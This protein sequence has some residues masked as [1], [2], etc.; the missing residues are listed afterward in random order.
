MRAGVWIYA[1]SLDSQQWDIANMISMHKFMHTV[2]HKRP[3]R[4]QHDR[5]YFTV[6]K[7]GCCVAPVDMYT[8]IKGTASITLSHPVMISGAGNLQKGWG[9]QA[10]LHVRYFILLLESTSADWMS[11]TIKSWQRLNWEANRPQE[12][13]LPCRYQHLVYSHPIHEIS[14]IFTIHNTKVSGA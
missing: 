6:R 7:S 1:L 14:S 11:K 12:Q 3:S 10:L 5:S 8:P 2:Q 13:A 9:P 4:H